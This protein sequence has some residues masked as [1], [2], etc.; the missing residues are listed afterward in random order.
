[1]PDSNLR[2]DLLNQIFKNVH[3]VSRF[4][5][6]FKRNST[7]KP[8]LRA[9]VNKLDFTV[10]LRY[11]IEATLNKCIVKTKKH[12]FKLSLQQET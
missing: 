11:F 9:T 7:M 2:P 10:L 3:Q 1:M 8:H 6:S 5:K 12:T 4:L